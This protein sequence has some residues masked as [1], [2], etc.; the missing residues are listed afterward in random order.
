MK[1][2]A[3][4]V[5]FKHMSIDSLRYD[6]RASS[7][8]ELAWRKSVDLDRLMP[9]K[10]CA[11]L[12]RRRLHITGIMVCFDAKF[13]YRPPAVDEFSIPQTI[14]KSASSLAA[15]NSG[16][17]EHQQSVSRTHCSIM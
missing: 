9:T 14:L 15:Y 10:S 12:S 1:F 11:V 6:N 17:H 16:K 2:G 5:G 3:T 8:R 7:L 4:Q 13:V